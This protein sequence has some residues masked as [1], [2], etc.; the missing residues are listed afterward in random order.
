MYQQ[1]SIFD[2]L[3]ST[4]RRTCV[5]YSADLGPNAFH[6]RFRQ[7][8]TSIA[9]TEEDMEQSLPLVH[10]QHALVLVNYRHRVQH[11]VEPRDIRSYVQSLLR[12]HAAHITCEVA[13]V[14]HDDALSI[15]GEYVQARRLT[16]AHEVDESTPL[17]A[18]YLFKL[19]RDQYLY[20]VT[21]GLDG[22]PRSQRRPAQLCA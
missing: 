7:A 16:H 19:E 18:Q 13:F 14:P 15:F 1:L 21:V 12:T 3:Y 8:A 10:G 17:G 4:R 2:R 6:D 22:V 20:T 11:D 5:A 9:V